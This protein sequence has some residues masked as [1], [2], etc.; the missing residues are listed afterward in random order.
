MRG[1]PCGSHPGI[2]SLVSADGTIVTPNVGLWDR[3]AA[4]PSGVYG[5]SCSGFP[6]E[7]ISWAPLAL[8]PAPAPAAGSQTPEISRRGAGAGFSPLKSKSYFAP[9]CRTSTCPNATRGSTNKAAIT[10][11]AL[12]AHVTAMKRFFITTLL[13]LPSTPDH[14]QAEPG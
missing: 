5:S 13:R 1:K 8:T 11:A 14:P 10:P 4:L 2:G 6:S 7:G 12:T 3:N 9:G